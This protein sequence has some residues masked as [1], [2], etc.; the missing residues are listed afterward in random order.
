[1]AAPPPPPSPSP[2]V[3][4]KPRPPP[5]PPPPP[6]AVGP[7]QPSDLRQQ[8][9]IPEGKL[10]QPG[11][12]VSHSLVKGGEVWLSQGRDATGA[13]IW[14]R[15]SDGKGSPRPPGGPDQNASSSNAPSTTSA[16]RTSV[17]HHHQLGDLDPDGV[18]AHGGETLSSN[19]D[20]DFC[21]YWVDPKKRCKKGKMRTF[22]H[23]EAHPTRY[24]EAQ[25]QRLKNKKRTLTVAE[26]GFGEGMLRSPKICVKAYL[27][28]SGVDS[29][30]VKAAKI[31]TIDGAYWVDIKFSPFQRPS[32]L[33]QDV[34][35]RF[36]TVGCNQTTI[37]IPG[38][39]PIHVTQGVVIEPE[40]LFW[41][42]TEWPSAVNIMKEKRL[43]NTSDPPAVYCL[44][45]LQDVVNYGYY[46]G[47]V[48]YFKAAVICASQ[49]SAKTLK[50][51]Y[52]GIALHYP[53]KSAPEWQIHED[54]IEV[55]G[56]V[57]RLEYLRAVIQ[58]W[59]QPQAFQLGFKSSASAASS[60]TGPPRA[61]RPRGSVAAAGSSI[62]EPV[63]ADS[64][65]WGRGH[66]RG[67]GRD[68]YH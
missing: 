2:L 58:E 37:E 62:Y 68:R 3:P 18:Q 28:S 40:V 7:K 34:R 30:I 42:G 52:P 61:V 67:R 64:S 12:A 13:T 60:S 55:L 50:R 53:N 25:K 4:P 14:G 10:S 6:K 57:T 38:L 15:A 22:F 56:V 5:P 54:S 63:G 51:C 46:G 49:T 21:V 20:L 36:A 23:D 48:F 32:V 59:H 8:W 24:H 9:L 17:G 44:R 1:M 65:S 66:G 43:R 16:R 47:A 27:R 26:A 33:S 39:L 35:D 29:D 19:L 31:D 11:K 41:H 45:S